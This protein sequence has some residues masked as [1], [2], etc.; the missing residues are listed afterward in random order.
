MPP[1]LANTPSLKV[2][3]PAN[4]LESYLTINR[5]LRQQNGADHRR[6][7]REERAEI[8]L[9]QGPFKQL[10][11]S[12]VESGF[13]DQRTYVYEG[14]DVDQQVHLGFDLASTAAAP[15]TASNAGASC[16]PTSSASTATA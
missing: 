1:I 7:G 3:D 16:S 8:A 15:V 6:A 13:A 10:V 9:W 11:N 14:R 12:A 4:L 5:E 2:D